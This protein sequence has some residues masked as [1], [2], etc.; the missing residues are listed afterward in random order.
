MKKADTPLTHPELQMHLW[1]L[2]QG[3]DMKEEIDRAT[4]GK[5]TLL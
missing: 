3:K 5:L 1:E 2:S 4:D